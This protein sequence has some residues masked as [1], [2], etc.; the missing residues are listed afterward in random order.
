MVI[1][2]INYLVC[3][4]TLIDSKLADFLI[5]SGASQNFLTLYLCKTNYLES[6]IAL[7]SGLVESV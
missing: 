5:G 1:I 2:L 4:N 6:N 7:K 3:L